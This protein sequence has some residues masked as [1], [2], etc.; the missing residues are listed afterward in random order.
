MRRFSLVRPGVVVALAA[1]TLLSPLA[2]A[3]WAPNGH[4]WN[5]QL[6]FTG[7][8]PGGAGGEAV[9]LVGRMH[10]RVELSGSE[11]SGFSL[12]LHA[13]LDKT[14]GT[15]ETSGQRYQ[16]DGADRARVQLA[17][18]PLAGSVVFNPSF[19]LHPPSPCRTLHP[20]SPCHEAGPFSARV[21]ASFN[22]DG[23]FS[24]DIALGD[25]AST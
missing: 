4:N 24:V 15:G 17:P 3:A 12:E 20:P 5:S 7:T 1:A 23:G 16:A 10:V 14:S 6:P 13:N 2:G 18:G 8:L 9:D 22:S 11:G 19:V 21:T 25:P